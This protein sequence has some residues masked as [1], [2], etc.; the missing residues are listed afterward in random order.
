MTT[1]ERKEQFPALREEAERRLRENPEAQLAAVL[2]SAKGGT[3]VFTSCDWTDPAP[4]EDLLQT[5][6]DSGDTEIEQL[7]YIWQHDSCLDLPSH[8]FR[9]ALLALDERNNDTRILLNG[10]DADGRLCPKAVRLGITLK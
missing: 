6:R 9:L 8:R 10:M 3:Y 5:L 4:E 2:R 1:E 7:V